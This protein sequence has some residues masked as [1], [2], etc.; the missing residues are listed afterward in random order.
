MF[1]INSK[2]EK[3]FRVNVLIF[4][5]RWQ[6]GRMHSFENRENGNVS[7]VRIPFSP[8]VIVYGFFTEAI[9]VNLKMNEIIKKN[10]THNSGSYV[11]HHKVINNFE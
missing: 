10:R 2:F 8:L 5:R 7:R 6:S 3:R 4:I 9:L 1:F 11:K